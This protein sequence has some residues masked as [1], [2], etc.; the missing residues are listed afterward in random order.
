ME[1]LEYFSL[2]AGSQAYWTERIAEGNW[3]AAPYL[4]AHLQNK[5][6]QHRYG[7]NGKVFLLTEGAHLI[8]FCTL[9]LQDEIKD[10]VLFPWIGF[11][12]TF[13]AYR[14]HRYSEALI[15]HACAAARNDGH[16]AVYLSSDEEGLY[17]KYG[18][19]FLEY[20]HTMDR[21]QTQVF[22]RTL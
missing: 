8:A 3:R 21:H 5:T 13:P 6:F 20:R 15:N 16:R 7:P 9:V 4:A 2:P 12:Y 10:D 22:Y 1:I 18:F 11:V 17:E 19:T 14:G